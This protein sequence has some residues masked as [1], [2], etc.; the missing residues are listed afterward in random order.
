MTTRRIVIVDPGDVDLVKRLA[1][2]NGV[3]ASELRVKGLEPVTTVTFVLVGAV[4]AVATVAHL[5]EAHKGGQLIDLRANA[6]QPICRTRNVVYGLVV[7]IS[8]EGKVSVEVKEPKEMFGTV[9]EALQKIA[10]DVG[11]AGIDAIA[12][13]AKQKFGSDIAVSLD[14]VADLPPS[15]NPN[16]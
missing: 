5:V 1:A 2:E 10:V 12:D 3:E 16:D 13:S 15:V 11:S 7:I 4:A 8:D 14:R 9:I 6:P